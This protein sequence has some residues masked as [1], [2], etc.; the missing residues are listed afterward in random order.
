[1]LRLRP[2]PPEGLPTINAGKPWSGE[3][4][5]DLDELVRERWPA[6]EIAEYLHREVFE[7]AAKIIERSK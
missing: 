6:R 2:K 7:V 1:M 3:D 4:L 5:A